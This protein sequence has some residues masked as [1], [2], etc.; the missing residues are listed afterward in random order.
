MT[1]V[2]LGSFFHED[3]HPWLHRQATSARHLAAL[4]GTRIDTKRLACAFLAPSVPALAS[5]RTYFSGVEQLPPGSRIEL[6]ATGDRYTCSTTWCPDP[7]DGPPPHLRLRNALTAAVRLRAD[8]DPALSS[9]L[10]G[11]LDSTTVAVLASRIGADPVNAVTIHPRGVLDGADLRYARLTV[12]ASRGRLRHQLL[13][14]GDLVPRRRAG[15][16]APARVGPDWRRSP[17][18]RTALHTSLHARPDDRRHP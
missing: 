2:G 1:A 18:G 11:G 12:A 10:S 9:D 8:T 3:D 14:L 6:P 17:R 13:P 4:V 7:L 5:G 16:R 15:P